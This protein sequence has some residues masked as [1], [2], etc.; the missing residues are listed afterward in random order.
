M[1]YEQRVRHRELAERCAALRDRLAEGDS[2]APATREE[3]TELT[4]LL[5]AVLE[6][7]SPERLDRLMETIADEAARRAGAFSPIK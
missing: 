2:R 4:D 1:T 3:A 7:W 6:E 5:V